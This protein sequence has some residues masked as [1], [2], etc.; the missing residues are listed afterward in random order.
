MKKYRALG[1]VA[2]VLALAACSGG[3]SG[4]DTTT[5]ASADKITGEIKVL[6]NRTDI[7]DTKFADYKKTFEAKYP[8]TKVTFQ[9]IK[10]YEGEVRTMMNTPE[11]GDVLLVPNSVTKD[12]L[13]TYFEPLGKLAD[14]KA[15]YRFATE[16]SFEDNVYGIAITGNAQ[17]FVY[18][19][20]VWA[21][22]GITEPPKTP[23]AF[24]AALGK[25]KATGV[26]PL[27]TNYKDGWPL[28]QWESLR[29]A[30]LNDTDDVN[31]LATDK[32]PWD[33][34]KTH[35][36]IDSLL[37]D[38]VKAGD[39]EADPTTTDWEGSKVLLGTGKIGTMMLGS[40]SIT[41]MQ[42]AATDA[43]DIGYM[44]FPNQVAGKYVSVIAGDYKNAVNI[45]SKNKAT[46]KAWVTWF[47]DESNYA[48]DNGG[49]APLLDAQ[50]PDAL[51]DLDAVK[52]EYIELDPEIAGKEGLVTRISDASEIKLFD[53]PYRQRLVDSARGATSETKA[54][55][56][57]DLNTKWAAAVASTT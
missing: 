19:K 28:T 26:I 9:A 48:V 41:Q 44:P 53:A 54:D 3:T 36:I 10:D 15:K 30:V 35:F 23:E 13:P 38:A 5:G 32:S 4:G 31:K 27:Y 47:A 12:Q 55:I 24:L 40:W 51:K 52:T 56:F 39:V 2:A 25:I 22:A 37:Y 8:G 17:G 18:N 46:A 20:K 49:I 11:Y 57:K 45:N 6:T 14:L 33:A 21:A 29:G 34:G 50:F 43:A 16:Q 1:A 7:V 42:G